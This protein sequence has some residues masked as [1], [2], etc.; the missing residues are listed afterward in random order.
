YGTATF[1]NYPIGGGQP[2]DTCKQILGCPAEHPLVVCPLPGE[3]LGIHE[4]VVNPG[5]AML[6][7]S[8]AA[9]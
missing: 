5:F 8:L 4:E 3:G 2:D 7:Q 6:L 1:E 9:P